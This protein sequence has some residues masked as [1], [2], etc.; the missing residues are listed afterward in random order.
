MIPT[1]VCLPLL[2]TGPVEPLSPLALFGVGAPTAPIATGVSQLARHLD[3]TLTELDARQ[4][5]AL[6]GDGLPASVRDRLKG[7]IGK[8]ALSIRGNKVTVKAEKFRLVGDWLSR[9]EGT[10]DL[11]TR[12]YK[13]K[14]WAFGGLVEAEGELPRDRP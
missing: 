3:V 13:L 10:A 8:V 4:V 1:F 9:A 2:F 7:R 12:K 6:F 11:G 14:L 5:A